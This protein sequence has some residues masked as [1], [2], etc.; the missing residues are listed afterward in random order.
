MKAM[1]DIIRTKGIKCD[2]PS[3]DWSNM[4]NSFKEYK[5][6]VDKPCPKCG[7]VVLTKRDY[8]DHQTFVRFFNNPLIKFLLQ[9]FISTNSTRVN[10]H[11]GKIKILGK[12]Y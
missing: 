3:C 11:N 4:L 7:E 6:W 5:D 2:N 10:V 9:P 8:K 12:G 1:K